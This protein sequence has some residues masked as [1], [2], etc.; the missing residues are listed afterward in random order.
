[1]LYCTNRG[2]IWRGAVDAFSRQISPLSVQGSG[3]WTPKLTIFKTYHG[4]ISCTITKFARLV[5][6][7]ALAGEIWVDSLEV[8]WGYN[9]RVTG[10]PLISVPL[11]SETTGQ[12]QKCDAKPCFGQN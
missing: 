2:K 5:G 9:L 1:M 7:F 4:L 12:T 8:L 10:Y 3:Y 11:S 6:G